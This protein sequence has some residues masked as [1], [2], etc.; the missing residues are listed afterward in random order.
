MTIMTKK[1]PWGSIYTASLSKGCQQ[2]ITGE[3]L[4][5]LV[6]TECSS[7]C[8]YCPL[9]YERK[10]SSYAF[11]NERPIKSI[12]DLILEAS[13]MDARGASM[14]GGD[15]LE[16]HSFSQ[17]LEFCRVLRREITRDFHIH[18][19]TRG[20]ELT[21]EILSKFAPHV[22]EIRFHVLNLQKDL[23]KVK[24]ATQFEIDVGIEVP[25]IPTKGFSYYRDLI[26]HFAAILPEKDQFYFVNLN[27]LEISET[28]YRNLLAH[29]LKQDQNNLSSIEGSAELGEEIVKW[30]SNSVSTPVHFCSLST[31]DS[32]Q[33]PNRIYRIAKNVRLSSDV[34][35]PDGPDKGLLLRGVIQ[36]P[37][38]DLDYLRWTLIE[39]LE[40]QEDLIHVDP[41]K[42]RL[43]TNAALLDELKNEIKA[44]F[45]DV[46]L[47]IVEEYPTYDNLQTT[48]IPLD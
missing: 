33:L 1:T 40:I 16:H 15:P 38:T 31:K 6:T 13:I 24:L 3:K 27:E 46:K 39:E 25:I 32:I 37:S 2:C 42:K 26:N 35:I 43:L 36:S 9:S 7:H 10:A 8:F 28:N 5:V 11:A 34:I 19:Y 29:G 45:P 21:P 14:T 17:T 22:D 48:F 12:D 30:A 41:R 4:V 44:I 23:I 47:G 20:K 18:L